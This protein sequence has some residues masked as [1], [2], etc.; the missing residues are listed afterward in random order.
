M[1]VL[2]FIN[3]FAPS[4]ILGLHVKKTYNVYVYLYLDLIKKMPI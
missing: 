3:T 1:R 2:I 4:I